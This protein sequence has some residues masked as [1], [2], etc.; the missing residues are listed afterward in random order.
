MDLAMDET[1]NHTESLLS[2]RNLKDPNEFSE[3]PYRVR[4][5]HG[6][7]E[8]GC[9]RSVKGS[10]LGKVFRLLLDGINSQVFIGKG[11]LQ[12]QPKA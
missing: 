3:F 10:E 11:L 9:Q 7:L 5:T 6:C 2:I 12:K 1:I 8:F 4:F